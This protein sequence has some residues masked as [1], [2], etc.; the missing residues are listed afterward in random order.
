MPRAFS[1][2]VSPRWRKVSSVSRPGPKLDRKWRES[3][4]CTC[5]VFYAY[6][7][8]YEHWSWGNFVPIRSKEA[9]Q[10]ARKLPF[11]L[12]QW[13]NGWMTSMRSFAYE[14]YRFFCF[15]S[16]IG[17]QDDMMECGTRRVHNG[18]QNIKDFRISKSVTR[19][20]SFQEIHRSSGYFWGS[21]A[22]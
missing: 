18:F 12:V 3:W 15:D 13:L 14:W 17:F 9:L 4:F 10:F 20:R 11:H 8:K 16:H 19:L 6:M 1:L 7:G 21:Q 22:L 2:L 5:L